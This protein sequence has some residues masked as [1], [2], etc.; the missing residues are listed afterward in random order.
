MNNSGRPQFFGLLAGLFLAAGLV[1]SAMLLTR[2]WLKISESQ[3]ITSTGSARKNVRSDLII[4]RG[5]FSVEAEMLSEAQQRLEHDLHIVEEFLKSNEATNFNFTPINIEELKSN[6]KT[7]RRI[8]YRLTQSVE[9]TSAEVEKIS[10]LD[11]ASTKLVEKGIL[12]TASLPQYI[13]TKTG[14]AKIEMLAEATRDARLRAEQICSQGNRVL[15]SLRSARIGVFQITPLYSS[16]T[17]S[18]GMN[19]ITSLDKTV[20]AVVSASFSLK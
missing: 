15:D 11:R 18:E 5:S 6:E 2:A 20:T 3:T 16:Q 13:Y 7:P 12:F 9:I 19:D 4:W 14:E 8:G 1:F 17:S 10:K